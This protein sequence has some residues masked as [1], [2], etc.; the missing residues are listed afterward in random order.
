MKTKKQTV[1]LREKELSGGAKSLYLEYYKDGKRKYEFLKIYLNKATT[2]KERSENR[3]KREL[4]ET[5]RT[6]REIQFKEKDFKILTDGNS[7]N[8]LEYFKTLLGTKKVKPN[9]KSAIVLYKE[10][11]G[12]DYTFKD[13][14]ETFVAKLRNRMSNKIENNEVKANSVNTYIAQLKRMLKYAERD[15]LIKSDV[16]DNITRFKSETP[17]KIYLT[18]E[19]LK[20]LASTESPD[21][22]V[23]DAFL[24]SC[25]TGLRY[26]DIQKLRWNEI[27]EIDGKHQ[28]V[29]TQKKTKG[30]E[31][32]PLSIQA[33]KIIEKHKGN[34]YV[35]DG[36]SYTYRI[37]HILKL[38]I[39][40]AGIDKPITF[41]SARHT[42]ATM[43]LTKGTDIYTVSKLL[44]H[45][46]ITTT[47]VY[48][49]IVDTVKETAIN[50][51][52]E[53]L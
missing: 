38:W 50:K 17:E 12:N 2:S 53:I 32:L 34:E 45:T 15:N 13:F 41:H 30:L 9:Y 31:Y 14:N 1:K 8:I 26:S 5:I 20:K 33:L 46:D 44:G 43:L 35:F 37:N 23:T 19:E 40:K 47:L 16:L 42:F 39:A 24:F 29:F 6:K 4:A 36:I 11:M 3:K 22:L 25:L 21:A 7:V 51:I 18:I 52:P 48:A 49:K 27:K 28:I 10:L